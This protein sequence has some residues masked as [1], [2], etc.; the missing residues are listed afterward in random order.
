[1]KYVFNA[2]TGKFDLVGPEQ[3]P[4]GAVNYKDGGL[5]SDLGAVFDMID[6]GSAEIVN[7]ICAPVFDLGEYLG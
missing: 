4:F 3:L 2:L 1:M 7:D 6:C 5:V